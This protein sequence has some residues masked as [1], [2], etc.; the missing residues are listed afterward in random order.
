M[1]IPRRSLL[2]LTLAALSNSFF[3]LGSEAALVHRYSF[4]TDASDAVGGANA[5]LSGGATMSPGKLMLDGQTGYADL[6]IGATI[7]ALQSFTVEAWVTFDQPA[8]WARIFDF[9]T[10]T[11]S[12]MFLTAQSNGGVIPIPEFGILKGAEPLTA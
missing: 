7:A 10:S 4:T 3:P 12:Y 1:T 6:P 9:G 11:S 5:T 8:Q 2:C